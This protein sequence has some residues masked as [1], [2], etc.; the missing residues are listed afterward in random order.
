MPQA[1]IRS[2][3]HRRTG[4]DWIAR[5]TIAISVVLFLISLT[6][7]G[8]YIDRA[9]NPRAWASCIGLLLIGWIAVLGGVSAWLANPALAITW[10]LMLFQRLRLLA[11]VIGAISLLFALSFLNVRQIMADESGNE[12]KITGY[13]A[14]YWIWVTSIGVTAVGCFA[15]WVADLVQ[16][17]CQDAANASSSETK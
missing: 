3:E 10:V 13:G 9:E 7:D 11:L 17:R 4:S 6:Q 8:F 15:A 1:S 2:S 12:S 5:S 14:G 16:A